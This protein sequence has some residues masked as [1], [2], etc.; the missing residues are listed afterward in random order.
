MMFFLMCSSFVKATT[1]DLIQ[2]I[3]HDDDWLIFTKNGHQLYAAHQASS[4][5]YYAY[6]SEKDE[7]S[8]GSSAQKIW[9]QLEQYFS[10]SEIIITVETE[11]PC[12][13]T[14]R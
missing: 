6:D 8:F 1:G 12:F 14:D 9:K 11:G 10:T 7:V 5:I 13:Y 4:N 2:R 3:E